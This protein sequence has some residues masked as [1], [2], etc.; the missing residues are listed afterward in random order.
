MSVARAAMIVAFWLLVGVPVGAQD[1][2]SAS[3]DVTVQLGVTAQ[4]SADEQVAVDNLFG[5]VTH[6]RC[7]PG[8]DGLW[9]GE[10]WGPSFGLRD[11]VELPG[12][13]FV[14]R[15]DVVR[16]DRVTYSIEDAGSAGVPEGAITD[17]VAESNGLLLSF[18]TTVD[19]A[20]VVRP[21][22]RT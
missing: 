18:D 9:E 3:P 17:A 8:C 15:G 22:M 5:I 20:G 2:V 13:V 6:S 10:Q 12:P 19:L 7:S 21:Q 16:Y 4:T 1:S 11:T 14:S